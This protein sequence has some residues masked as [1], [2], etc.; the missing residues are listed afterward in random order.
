MMNNNK[1]DFIVE[2]PVCK[3]VEFKYIMNAFTKPDNVDLFQEKNQKYLSCTTCGTFIKAPLEK[4]KENPD[5]YGKVYYNQ[6]NSVTED[7]D[8]SI[9]DHIQN[10][11]IPVYKTFEKFIEKNFD[12]NKY[13]YWLDIGS[14]GYPTTFKN[15][16][17]TTIEPDPRT[18]SIGQN[19]FKN[20]NIICDVFDNYETD[21][22]INGIVFHHSFYCIPNPNETLKKAYEMLNDEG[23]IIIAIGQYFMGTA[24]V[25]EDSEFLRLE[26]IFR[27]ETL[28]TYYNQ[29]SLEYL[30]QNNGFSLEQSVILNHDEYKFSKNFS[31][32]YFVFKKKTNLNKDSKLITKSLNLYKNSLTQTFT[33]WE[34]DTKNTLKEFNTPNTIFIGNFKLFKSLNN[35]LK[36]DNVYG[37]IDFDIEYNNTYILDDI[38]HIPYKTLEEKEDMKIIVCSFDNQNEILNNIK[39][40]NKNK[41]YTPNRQSKIENL[42]FT[43]EEKNYLTKAFIVKKV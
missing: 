28:Y 30:F 4:T 8:N 6:M 22:K 9:K 11:Q 29:Y 38:Q 37:F 10:A 25:F 7:I 26:D 18:V 20:K 21:K 24:S 43:Y 16:E 33:N 17:F 19:L 5:E 34:K 39:Q 27:G 14:A 13:K 36:L 31:S 2:C 42:F 23:I 15:Y 32:K 3:N 40:Y 1:N 35:I 12:Y 41:I